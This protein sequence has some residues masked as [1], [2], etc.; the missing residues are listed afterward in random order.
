MSKSKIVE[1]NIEE[2]FSK[3]SMLFGVVERFMAELELNSRYYAMVLTWNMKLDNTERGN[4]HLLILLSTFLFLNW[5]ELHALNRRAVKFFFHFFTVMSF[6]W[7]TRE[8]CL[9]V[10]NVMCVVC[11]EC[12]EC[13]W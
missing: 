2:K 8:T 7:H 10:C 12:R 1:L 11:G 4:C 3:R 13:R 9:T 5:K 6:L